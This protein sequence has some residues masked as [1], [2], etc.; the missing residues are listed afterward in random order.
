MSVHV[1]IESEPV[2]GPGV[3]LQVI[4]LVP[5]LFM[6][7]VLTVAA[8]AVAV[9]IGVTVVAT[10]RV[11]QR[12]AGF[13]IR[14]IRQR[15][16]TFSGFFLLRASTPPWP[17][18]VDPIDPGDDSLITVSVDV[19]S[20]LPRWAPFSHAARAGAHLLVLV[21]LAVLLDLL[22]PLWLVLVARRGWSVVARLRLI[23][24]EQW[25]ADVLAHAW[26]RARRHQGHAGQISLT[27]SH[28]WAFEVTSNCRLDPISN[29]AVPG[30]RCP[31][32]DGVESLDCEIDG[33]DS[34]GDD[35]RQ[36]HEFLFTLE[37]A[38]C[39]EVT[40]GKEPGSGFRAVPAHHT[41]IARVAAPRSSLL[42][43]ERRGLRS[44]GPLSG[45]SRGHPSRSPAHD[46]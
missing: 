43:D 1:E 34:G 23:A 19:P 42:D 18:G 15:T 40:G 35:G 36:C 17:A 41:T 4:R 32:G 25:T 37:D 21:P 8:T 29:L 22:Y 39:P 33:A 9:A 20:S 24:V 16:R 2:V 7:G 3:V 11:P 14:A 26:R 38:Q 45:P 6:A 31:S 27:R 46:R 10:G 13:Q 44:P 28:R 5:M 30:L 12:L